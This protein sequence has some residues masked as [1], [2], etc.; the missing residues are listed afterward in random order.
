MPPVCLQRPVGE[1]IGVPAG[2]SGGVVAG[3]PIGSP[4]CGLS[5]GV[6]AGMLNGSL[7]PGMPGG[8]LGS[9][10][11]GDGCGMSGVGSLGMGCSSGIGNAGRNLPVPASHPQGIVSKRRDG[12]SRSG[13]S[14]T[15]QKVKN[16][17]YERRVERA[18][19]SPCL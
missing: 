2:T 11:A 3:T 15:W 12:R 4:T 5:L 8:I 6:L 16:P 18:K 9:V 19:P 1:A 10:G 13:R 7:I 17:S 14:L